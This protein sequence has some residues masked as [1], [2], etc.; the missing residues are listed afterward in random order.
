[1]ALL[2]TSILYFVLNSNCNFIL[3][4]TCVYLEVLILLLLSGIIFKKIRVFLLHLKHKKFSAQVLLLMTSITIIPAFLVLA[5]SVAIF[6]KETNELFHPPIKTVINKNLHLIN[7]YLQEKQSILK[8][9]VSDFVNNIQI[10]KRNKIDIQQEINNIC[11][12]NQL[13]ILL[14]KIENG[15]IN[16]LISSLYSKYIQYLFSLEV[17]ANMPMN[18]P[19]S[20]IVN[21]YIICILRM[22]NNTFCAFANPIDPEIVSLKQ[23][24]KK[25]EN[26]YQSLFT[27]HKNLQFAFISLFLAIVILLLLLVL[28]I[29]LKFTNSILSPIMR[30]INGAENV[31]HGNYVSISYNHPLNNELETLIIAFNNMVQQIK[32]QK[33]ETKQMAWK[34]LS[35]KMA[36]EIKNPLTPIL[37]SAERLKNNY[38][39][40]GQVKPEVFNACINTI[41][42]QVTCISNLVKEF[43]DF[44]RMPPPVFATNN[45]VDILQDVIFI[46]ANANK[47]IIFYL[48]LIGTNTYC[49]CDAS[50]INQVF[51]NLIQNA[52]NA[53]N[54]SGT[55]E[56]ISY[57][58][59]NLSNQ[60]IIGRGPTT[61]NNFSKS[62]I[63]VREES[64]PLK[65]TTDISETENIV[66][67]KNRYQINNNLGIGK[68]LITCTQCVENVSITIE[69]NGSGFSEIAL[70]HAFDPYFTTGKTGTGLG[71]AIVYKIISDH[72]GTINIEKS[73]IL[74]GAKLL[75]NIPRQRNTNE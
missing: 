14:F 34:D 52:I 12:N 54:E 25:A 45:I 40:I 48:Q 18:V 15:F 46:Q 9:Y 24:L 51:I 21:D 2:V 56:T 31:C 30:L 3:L 59:N 67:I 62:T 65:V 17:I 47:N 75:I 43:S 22:D 70:Q 27:Q 28:F 53:V 74:G 66:L 19:I 73:E 68:I 60:D 69:D 49:Y 64:Y 35:R 71:L 26:V 63:N 4:F 32:K 10:D 72:N 38:Q 23:Q 42:R 36:H 44:A 20:Y 8:L 61:V 57:D 16:V 50:Q 7:L 13:D 29:A 55:Y 41:I 39:K 5:F 6:Q 37:L 33:I 1:M 11:S 58:D